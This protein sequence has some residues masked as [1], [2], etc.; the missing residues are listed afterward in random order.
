MANRLCNDVDLFTIVMPIKDRP[1]FLRSALGFLES[2]G[3][4]GQ[5]VI[6]DGSSE[7]MSFA[8]KQVLDSQK[9]IKIFVS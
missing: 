9:K 3:F 6:A 1:E 7:S 2:Q 4:G 5:V 8:N